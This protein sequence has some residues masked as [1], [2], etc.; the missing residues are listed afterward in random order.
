VYIVAGRL[1]DAVEAGE[2]ALSNFE[3]RGDLWW[4]ART[5]W[6]LVMAANYLGEWDASLKYC[7]RAL[8]H[9]VAVNDP[10]FK[11]V[12][13]VGLWRMGSTCIQQGDLQRGL[14]CC[15]E[16]LALTPI[17]RDAMMAK[18]ACGYAEIKAGR[19]DAGIAQ[20]SEALAWFHQSDHR[21]AYLRYALWLAEG[22]LRRGDRVSARPLVDD[23]LNTSRRLGYVHC[24]GLACWLT[25]ECL[26]TEAPAAA[27]KYVE[28][29][30]RILEHVGARNDLARAMITQAALSLGVGDVA[31]ARQLLDQASAIFRALGTLDEPAR[32]EAALAAL[33]RGAPIRLLA[34]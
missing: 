21:Y 5:L 10:R 20:L 7:R 30:I 27:G 28:T 6:F 17:P 14:E 19:I 4:A 34:G 3:A 31:T 8:Q 15:N 23:A 2:R 1:R 24:E 29:A 33:N 22:Y 26:A 25:A 32:V 18:A 9:G 11:S 12:R 16:A 13:A